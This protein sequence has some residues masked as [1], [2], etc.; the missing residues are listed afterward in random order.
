MLDRSPRNA[1]VSCEFRLAIKKQIVEYY[2]G[3]PIIFFKNILMSFNVWDFSFNELC[4]L[5]NLKKLISGSCPSPIIQYYI[6]I[7]FKE[8]IWAWSTQNVLWFAFFFLIYFAIY[9]YLL[10]FESDDIWFQHHFIHMC[11]HPSFFFTVFKNWKTKDTLLKTT[12][13]CVG[14]VF[15]EMFWCVFFTLRIFLWTASKLL[16]RFLSVSFRTN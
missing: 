2:V 10:F 8:N 15:S 6:N 4:D 7:F 13:R 14:C 1:Y 9:N 3:F 12:H 16:S 5:K 11:D